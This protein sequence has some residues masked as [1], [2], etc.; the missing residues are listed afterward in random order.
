MH[1]APD[2]DEDAA[3]A[4]PQ[5]PSVIRP[6]RAALRNMQQLIQLRWIAVVGQIATILVVDYG[7]GIDLPLAMMCTVL[8]ALAAF[9]L[10]SQLWWRRRGR[11]SNGALLLGL[12]VDVASLTVQLY[13]S[14]GITNPF[15]FLYL[16]QVV[17]GT[18]LLRSPASWVLAAAAGLCVTGLT[19]VPTPLQLSAV[20][21]NGL[22]DHYVQ[23]LLICFLLIA[24][25]LVVFIT[26]IGRIL[27]ERDARLA[28]L[29]QR[30]AEED[31]IVRMGLLA[32]G[33][34]HELGT[35][36][37]ILSVILGDWRRLPAV[38]AD[39]E[40]DQDVSEMQAQVA[41]CK[42]IVTNILLSAGETR[43]E[44]PIETTLHA[45][46]DEL[47]AEWRAA[48][49]PESFRYENR[50][51]DNPRIVSDAGLRQMVFNVLDN[52]LEASPGWVG[53]EAHCRDGELRIE[54]SD[55]GP[56][57]ERDILQ[58]LGSPYNSSKGRP[59]GGL[60]L[61][62]SVNVARTLGG[63]LSAKNRS[64]GGAT[65]TLALPLSAIAIEEDGD[66]D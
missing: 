39:A 46:L 47:A 24:A 61:F 17:L 42:S 27:R 23:G 20:P 18:V 60:G 4:A 8:A 48:R 11:V 56:G 53:L 10:G 25:L 66:D 32:S 15:V 59:G 65:V 41:R 6:D 12:L 45:L 14:G 63:S 16:L 40:L 52:A 9:N 33:A 34:A 26:R 30:A 51:S 2:R 57:F 28:E 21:A 49:S 64:Q 29:R 7:L 62:L 5:G 50:C 38:A 55:A 13:L 22:A 1:T 58:R 44:A 54:V 3:D 43:G 19:L 37:A 36:L 35:P 31:H